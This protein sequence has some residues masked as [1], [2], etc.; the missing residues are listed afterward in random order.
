MNA[1][2][3][4]KSARTLRRMYQRGIL[5]V[6]KDPLMGLIVSVVSKHRAARVQRAIHRGVRA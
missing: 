3:S 6:I 1:L 4:N 2:P 5:Q